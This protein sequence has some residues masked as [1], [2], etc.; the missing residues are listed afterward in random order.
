MGR[1]QAPRSV[2]RGATKLEA[3]WKK[4]GIDVVGVKEGNSVAMGN[5][6][7]QGGVRRGDHRDFIVRRG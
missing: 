5:G 1:S 3:K 2:V 6:I 4:A 7:V